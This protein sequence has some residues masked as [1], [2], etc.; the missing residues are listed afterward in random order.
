MSRR[1]DGTV[2]PLTLLSFLLAGLLVTAGTAASAAFLAQRDL[3]GVCDGAAVAGA[4]AV[5]RGAVDSGI[6][7][8]DPAA[9]T[10]ATERYRTRAGKPGLALRAGTDG[11]TVTVECRR[12]VRIPF[13][14]V[15]GKGGGLEGTAV[16]RA[17]SAVLRPR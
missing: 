4:A 11:R 7:P 9:V 12:T 13:G 10:A 3:A 16:A 1:D 14:A 17:R 6:L 15:L 2:I 5:G 8:L